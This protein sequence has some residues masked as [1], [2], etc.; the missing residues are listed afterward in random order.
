MVDAIAIAIAIVIVLAIAVV[1][2]TAVT[3]A[4]HST[5]LIQGNIRRSR[6]RRDRLDCST[7]R[8]RSRHGININIVAELLL[9]LFYY[10]ATTSY[11]CCVF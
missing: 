4:I 3:G 6:S 10:Y 2:E 11:T 7:S 5:S 9:L 8:R 1:V